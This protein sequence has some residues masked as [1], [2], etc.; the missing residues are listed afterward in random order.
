MTACSRKES[1]LLSQ[2]AST[3]PTYLSYVSLRERERERERERGGG[4]GGSVSYCCYLQ[5]FLA[6]TLQTNS[7][8]SKADS[9]KTYQGIKFL[10]GLAN[11]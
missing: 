3:S 2:V 6:D 8:A 10:V 9:K 4:G 1:V 11:K 7:S 5:L